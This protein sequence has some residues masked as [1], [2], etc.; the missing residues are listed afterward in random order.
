MEGEAAKDRVQSAVL[1]ELDARGAIEDTGSFADSFGVD[2]NAV[3]G[4]ILSLE[5]LEM[6]TR[7]VR[8]AVHS[9]IKLHLLDN[10]LKP[11]GLQVIDHSRFVLTD[12]AKEYLSAG[13]PEAQTFNAVPASGIGLHELQV[14][15][16]CTPPEP[17]SVLQQTSYG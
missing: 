5:S 9:L 2:H 15:T 3:Y 12:E 6:V 7:K 1:E 17:P 11:A 4:C 10:V 14:A 16:F 8:H 13:S